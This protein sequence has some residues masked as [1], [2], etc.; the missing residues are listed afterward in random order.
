MEPLLRPCCTRR[1]SATAF[2]GMKDTASS[3]MISL[4][5]ASPVKGSASLS[6]A[7]ASSGACP[8]ISMA[9]NE[10]AITRA[11]LVGD[12][13]KSYATR[14]FYTARGGSS[15]LA[16]RTVHWRK[17]KPA[18]QTQTNTLGRGAPAALRLRPPWRPSI[19][20]PTRRRFLHARRHLR[21]RRRRRRS[22]PAPSSLEQSP[23]SRQP[24]ALVLPAVTVP[25]LPCSIAPPRPFSPLLSPSP[26]PGRALACVPGPTPHPSP[27]SP[28]L[29]FA[30]SSDF[31][32][33]G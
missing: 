26:S 31:H 22:P 21:R 7:R 10:G 14:G 11:S 9:P 24:R 5:S 19:P 15:S 30:L 27:L 17:L 29:L 4:D 12:E 23:A 16:Y 2:C 32:C 18:N 20:V 1:R 3:E 28:L 25:I 33:A 13:A 8:A 6:S